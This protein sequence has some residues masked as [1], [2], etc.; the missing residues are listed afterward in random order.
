MPLTYTGRNVKPG[1][2]VH[3]SLVDIAVGLSRQPRFAGQTRRWWSVL[4]HT[5]F[6]AAL[7]R[8]D[9]AGYWAERLELAWLLH[10]AHEAITGDIP[11]PLKTDELRKTQELLDDAIYGAFHP[12][13]KHIADEQHWLAGE[14]KRTDRRTLAAEAQVAA[15]FNDSA[16][17]GWPNTSDVVLLEEML[18]GPLLGKPPLEQNAPD[19]PAVQ[20]Y[21][22][23]MIELM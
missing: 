19:H 16:A 21:I 13:W 14:V 12:K 4:D 5:L 10:D 22:N 2:G 6:G 7:I 17:F 23:R 20:E 1:N 3:P 8:Q 18:Q 11:T 9:M 15:G